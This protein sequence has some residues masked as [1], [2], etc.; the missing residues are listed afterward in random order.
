M[1][2]WGYP[3][4]LLSAVAVVGIAW[5][6][7]V[8]LHGVPSFARVDQGG[9]SVLLGRHVQSM[10]YWALQPLG[11]GLA[12]VG[13]SADAVTWSSLVLGL[14][15]GAALADGRFGLAALVG[16][17]SFLCDAVD[18][19]VARLTGT[20]SPAGEVLDAAIDRYV[21]FAWMG[22]LA[23]YFRR[24]ALA[25]GLV[26]AALLGAVS[27]SYATAKAE[28]MQV[29][30]PRGAMRRVERCVY[31]CAGAAIT[32]FA[33]LWPLPASWQPT[34]QRLPAAWPM[35]AVLALIAV[36][37]NVSAIRRQSALARAV[38]SR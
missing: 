29:A 22:G 26:L 14:L 1:P 9:S 6:G 23:L 10:A 25:L 8:A 27:V 36:V 5:G 20:A 21:D 13:V 3:L 11:R 19:L 33:P 12:A 16:A 2:D 31:L 34:P 28:A 35:L 17:L 32:S 37:A 30:V 7:R 24:D 15:A 18:G 38:R 4:V